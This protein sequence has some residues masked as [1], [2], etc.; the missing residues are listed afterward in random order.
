MWK[1]GWRPDREW[2]R[3]N[4]KWLI[5]FIVGFLFLVLSFPA[6]KTTGKEW[7][8]GSPGV[9]ERREEAVRSGT[10]EGA[11][12]AVPVDRSGRQYEKE[13]EKS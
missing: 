9:V 4:E 6:G 2:I 3:K 8:A 1:S 5:L 7:Y 13:I 10:G 12:Q 11:S